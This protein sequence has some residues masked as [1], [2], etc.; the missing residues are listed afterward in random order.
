MLP[1]S[2]DLMR[3]I[4]QFNV[5][6][7]IRTAGSISRTELSE[8]TGQS[9]ASVTNITARLIAENLI[10]EK[11]TSDSALRGRRRVL[12]ALNADA[13]YV[14]GIKL[15]AFRI[16][17]AVTDMQADVRSSIVMPVRT[18]ERSSSFVADLI[19]EGIRH[20][21]KDARLQMD[22]IAGIGIGVPG[23]VD[24]NK[25]FCHWTPLY[26]K[27]DTP[28]RDL[29]EKRLKI[30]T[31]LENDANAV[32]MAHQW[33]GDGMG[34]Q[35]FVV[36]TIEDGV[37]MGAVVNGQLYRGASG[38][39]SEFGHVVVV[40]GGNLC[41]CGK[42]GCLEAYVSDFSIL[43]AAREICADIRWECPP[44]GE[45]TLDDVMAVA[46]RG[47]PEMVR[48]FSRAGRL[49]G[50]GVA[51]II[52]ILNPSKII[53]SGQGVR[54]GDLMFAPMRAV[55]AEQCNPALHDATEIIIHK[56][57]DTDW[58]RGAASLVLQE[59]YKTPFEKIRPVI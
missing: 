5:L 12:L 14:V 48:I 21:V 54:A 57:Q 52:Q 45:L 20:C 6:N 34:E 23:F 26:R 16:S 55:V 24:R 29:V 56:W 51:G 28:L 3:A 58:A 22:Q 18:S 17:C 27:G 19:E 39:G 36:I 47:Q 32:T 37:G 4:N 59:L 41:R 11:E 46:R 10:Y 13:A 44:R 53:L 49:L 9:R 38:F 33:F 50:Q 42:R 15:S 31:Y 43:A 35:N 40:P 8:I 30:R 25:G 2:R 1:A 7:T